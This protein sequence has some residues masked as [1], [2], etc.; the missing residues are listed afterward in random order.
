MMTNQRNG[1]LYIDVTSDLIKRVWQHK[2]KIADG[3][4]K[5]YH[6]HSLVLYEPHETMESAITREKA[7]K[8]WQRVWKVRLI[9]QLNPNWRDL[10]FE[11]L[12]LDS[13]L[14]QNDD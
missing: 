3:F 9:E 12:G 2:N 6:L 7:L 5:K 1:T 4:T 10:Y 13:G 14:R 8:F 11:L